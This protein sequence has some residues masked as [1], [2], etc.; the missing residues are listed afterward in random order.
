MINKVTLKQLNF[1]KNKIKIDLNLELQL[2]N[3][4]QYKSLQ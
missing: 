3:N 4:N 2:I 1:L